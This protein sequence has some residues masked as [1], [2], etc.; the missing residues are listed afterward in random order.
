MG[1]SSINT[2]RAALLALQSVNAAQRDLRAAQDRVSTGLKVA[3]A[4]DNAAVWGIGQG[5]RAENF[6]WNAV[7]QSLGRAGSVL[8]VAAA[9]AGAINDLLVNLRGKAQAFADPSLSA[10]SRELIRADMEALITQIDRHADLAG[11]DGINLVN[12]GATTATVMRSPSTTYRLTASPLTPQSFMT[13]MAVG[14]A[15]SS[16]SQGMTTR[17]QMSAPYSPLTPDSFSGYAQ[18]RAVASGAQVSVDHTLLSGSQTLNYDHSQTTARRLEFLFDAFTEGDVVEVW[19]NGVRV[20]ATGQP[21]AFDGVGVGPGAAAAGRITLAFD[22][23]PA[24]GEDVEVRINPGGAA[25]GS[26]LAYYGRTSRAYGVTSPGHN[27]A[28]T[29]STFAP[30]PSGPLSS[31][32][33]SFETAGTPAANG[34]QTHVIDAGPHAGRVDLLFDASNTPDVVEIWQ[35]GMR[36]AASGQAYTPGGGAVAAGVPTSGAQVISF[37]YDPASGQSLEFRFNEN[38]AHV[39]AAWMVGGLVLQDLAAP[40]P[41]PSVILTTTQ[42]VQ[43]GVWDDT[44]FIG[45]PPPLTPED[46]AAASAS[47]TYV[48]DGGSYEGRVDLAFDAYDDADVIEI[49]QNGVRV[50]ASG[51]SYVSGGGA[52]PAGEPV[53]GR[54]ILSFDYDPAAGQSLEFRFNPGDS[55]SGAWT[56]TGLALNPV[57]SPA[58]AVSITGG[59]TTGRQLGLAFPKTDMIQSPDGASLELSARDLTAQGLGLDGLDWTN[60]ASILAALG[61]AIDTALEAGGY[62]GGRQKLVEALLRQTSRLQNVLDSG[63]GNLVD[64]DM[65][66]D[67][68]QLQA[69][70][71]RRELA[72]QTLSIANGQPQTLLGLFKT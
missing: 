67:A 19:Q 61:G 20:A 30:L 39:G 23:D 40:R 8:D 46:N 72:L 11:F 3:G 6:G 59:P 9:A 7:A 42:S 10:R 48:L 35:D 47:R 1:T 18:M 41:A 57:G 15:N 5:M 24:R 4:R 13:P 16:W 62:F 69:A 31:D 21:Q 25:P 64:A 32:P 71:I 26:A 43:A 12:G 53:A 52:V 56:V 60:P 63:V 58:P 2:N 22:F 17:T 65:A 38:N 50:A 55:A 66:K 51:Q 36:V 68:A 44:E 49:W 33:L 34:V 45:P 28:P 37:D 54:S 14:S 70:Q 27:E 29:L